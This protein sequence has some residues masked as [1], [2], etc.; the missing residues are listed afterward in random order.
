MKG[1]SGLRRRDV[2]AGASALALS[3][4]RAHARNDGEVFRPEDFGAF[5]DGVTNDTLALEQL[6]AA[7]T[8]NGGGVVELRQGSV[9]LVGIQERGDARGYGYYLTPR[10]L[11]E[12]R[13]C[14]RPLVIRGNGAR[15]RCAGGLKY[16]TF[17]PETGEPHI[18]QG[19]HTRIA[20]PYLWMIKAEDCIGPIEISDLELDGNLDDHVL[21]GGY[22]D[23]GRQIAAVGIG[24]YN[25]HGPETLRR[26][27][28]HHHALDG[29]VIDGAR[30][31]AGIKSQIED[32]ICADNGRQ[33]CSIVGGND[34]HFR[35]CRFTGTGGGPVMS[36]PG[37]GVDIEAEGGK[38][39]FNLAFE[40]CLF[41]DNAGVGM[42]TG[43]GPSENARFHRCTFVGTNSYAVWPGRPGYSFSHCIF[44]GASVSAY[45]SRERPEQAASFTDCLFTDDPALSPTGE[46]YGGTGEGLPI[47]AL[48][49]N[50]NVRFR[51]CRFHLVAAGLLPW[52]TNVTIFEDCTMSQRSSVLSYPRGTFI[53]RNV[54]EGRA[55]PQFGAVRGELIV[56]GQHIPRGPII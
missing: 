33:G 26:I 30:R 29:V 56:N 27:Y 12:F 54:I 34:Y 38:T 46:V 41:S 20:T 52:T 5:G 40:S 23:T 43:G 6:A 2:L 36:A 55:I 14:T 8:A 44:V 15:I 28:A 48:P 45:G 37:A 31:P 22:D 17:D 39:V 18:G 47:F 50:P 9:Y 42:V 32:V 16:G 1:P 4:R 21:G 10:T 35:H 7:V 3:A 25:N 13:G 19:A 24:L 53:G 11:L 51:R 49:D